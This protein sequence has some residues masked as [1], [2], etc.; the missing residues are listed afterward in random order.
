MTDD[1]AHADTG[2]LVGLDVL[3]LTTM[4]SGGFATSLL[5][6]FGADVVSVEHPEY[7]DPIRTWNP[8]AAG[9]SLWWKN[10]GRNKRHVTLDLSTD[11]GRDLAL[12]LAADVDV[13]VENFRPG[14][15]ERWGLGPD[16]LRE[17][18]EKLI[19]VRISGFGQTGPAAERPG[20]GTIAEG[21][22]T[23]AH[24]NGFPDSGPLLPPIPIA[25]LMAGQSAAMSALF[26]VY[27]R[28]LGDTSSPT[29]GGSERGGD[30]AGSS[31]GGREAGS[32]GSGEGQVIDVSLYEPL[33]R[34]MIGAVEGYDVLGRVPGRHGNVSPNAAPRNIYP[35]ADGHVSLSASTQRIF[36]NVAAAIDRPELVD[37]PRFE[38][39]DARVNHRA[40]LDAIIRE[41][42]SD[43]SRAEV[44]SV[45]RDHD[46]IVGPIYDIADVFDDEQFAARDTLLPVDDDDLGEVRTQAPV[47]SFSRTPGSVDHLGGDHGEHNEE[48]YLDELDL[49]EAQLR[50]LREEGVV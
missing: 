49:S 35:T 34:T 38:T 28:E 20:F 30:D 27:E 8:S 32:C 45:M 24:V 42:T 13:L 5:A 25:D 46:A 33:F 29:G 10:L 9:E 48:V 16:R 37:D 1:D 4:I 19:V 7:E 40:E 50:S 11:R 23:F 41:W 12:Q 15:L 21:L 47:P 31:E 6:D 14:T 22:S 17:R 3:D 44:L 36:E 18:N 26:A 43:R 2:P 39:N